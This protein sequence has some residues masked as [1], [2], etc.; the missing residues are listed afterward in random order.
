MYCKIADRFFVQNARAE[1]AE[2]LPVGVSQIAAGGASDSHFICSRGVTSQAP[3]HKNRADG[4][5][6]ASSGHCRRV[7]RVGGKSQSRVKRRCHSGT[8]LKSAFNR[9]DIC[10]VRAGK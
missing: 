4:F 5:G 3:V 9:L 6:C 2:C 8:S 10:L 7:G 1:P